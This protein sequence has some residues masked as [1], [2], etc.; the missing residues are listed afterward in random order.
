MT[1]FRDDGVDVAAGQVHFEVPQRLRRGHG[2]DG[3][4]CDNNDNDGVGDNYG[5]DKW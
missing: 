4:V 3:D 5:G 2:D 1:H